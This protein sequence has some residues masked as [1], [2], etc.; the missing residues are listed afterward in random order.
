MRQRGV[1]GDEEVDMVRNK[2]EMMRTR[3][4]EGEKSDSKEA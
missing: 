2:A 3:A 4:T 1:G